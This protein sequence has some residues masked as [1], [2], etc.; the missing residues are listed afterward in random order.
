MTQELGIQ[1]GR[2]LKEIREARGLTQAQ[3][4]ELSLRSVETIS[5]FER[6]KTLPGLTTL[7]MLS[8][9]LHV[10]M[11]D[12]FQDT[13]IEPRGPAHSGAARTIINAIDILPDEDLEILV[14]VVK[15]LEKRHR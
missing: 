15:V 13:D 4:A 11:K 2:R 5:N 10:Q 6:G 12:F 3:L 7:E 8:Q 1:L 9:R 14:G